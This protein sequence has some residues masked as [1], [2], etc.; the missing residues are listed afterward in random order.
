MSYDLSPEHIQDISKTTEE[1][2]FEPRTW[3][4]T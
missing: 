2:R 1:P 3:Q 4:G